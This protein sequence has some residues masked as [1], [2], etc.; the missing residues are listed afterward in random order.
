MA[1]SVIEKA[2]ARGAKP[3]MA[4]GTPFGLV[5]SDTPEPGT[6][7]AIFRALEASSR[8]VIGPV[9]ARLLVIP[10]RDDA[11]T[12]A[13]G[14]WG[15]TLFEW[16]QIEMLFVPVQLRGRGVGSALM[17]LAERSARDRGCRGAYVDTF[18]FQAAP[19]YRKLGFTPFGVLDDFPPGHSRLYFRKCFG[20]PGRSATPLVLGQRAG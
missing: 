8:P 19:F 16:L 7:E 9:N 14:L 17:T 6:F 15:S 10:I 5:P 12:V 20:Q 13:G 4:V 3:G 18:S 1:Q 2:G 11:G